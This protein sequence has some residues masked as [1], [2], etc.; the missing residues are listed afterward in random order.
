MKHV[1]YFSRV[2][3]CF[4]T[5][6]HLLSIQKQ[7][8]KIIHFPQKSH[9]AIFSHFNS[10]IEKPFHSWSATPIFYRTKRGTIITWHDPLISTFPMKICRPLIFIVQFLNRE[11]MYAE[12]LVTIFFIFL[13][14]PK[15]KCEK[16]LST[17]TI[18][19]RLRLSLFVSDFQKNKDFWKCPYNGPLTYFLASV[20]WHLKWH[21]NLL[22]NTH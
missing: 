10:R 8:R 4:P 21:F 2:K 14:K 15:K 22:Q 5:L 19:S 20:K 18:Y 3:N 11:K 13:K 16:K 6:L 9:S 17:V 12:N 7:K 1:W